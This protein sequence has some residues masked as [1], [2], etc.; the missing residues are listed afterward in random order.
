MDTSVSTHKEYPG[1]IDRRRKLTVNYMGKEQT[2]YVRDLLY[3]ERDNRK[4]VGFINLGSSDTKW[5][6][7]VSINLKLCDLREKY[8][9]LL[10]VNERTLVNLA[11]VVGIVDDSIFLKSGNLCFISRSRKKPSSD[12]IRTMFETG[13]VNYL[14]SC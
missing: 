1:K 7:R 13:Q 4:C 8:H 9:V 5:A 3:V 14:R 11:H 10:E 12:T 2:V 6:E